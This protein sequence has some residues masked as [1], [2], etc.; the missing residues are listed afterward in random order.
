MKLQKMMMGLAALAFVLSA[1]PAQAMH[2]CNNAKT[3]CQTIAGPASVEV[4]GVGS[5]GLGLCQLASADAPLFCDAA[6]GAITGAGAATFASADKPFNGLTG[7][8]AGNHKVYVNIDYQDTLPCTST[9]AVCGYYA[10]ICNDRDL[11]S[12][13]TNVGD[14]DDELVDAW[15]NE[16][17]SDPT[18]CD[19][20]ADEK[21]CGD[22]TTLGKTVCF[23]PSVY[24]GAGTLA[25]PADPGAWNNADQIVVFIGAWA[26]KVA[27]DDPNVGAGI[28]AGTYE[29]SIQEQGGCSIIT[30]VTESTGCIWEADV[31]TAENS[32]LD[33]VIT[34]VDALT[35]TP[36]D[37]N[38]AIAALTSGP[39]IAGAGTCED[40]GGNQSTFSCVGGQ[41][42]VVFVI[43]LGTS[44]ATGTG[45]CPT[46]TTTF[47]TSIADQGAIGTSGVGTFTCGYLWTVI[48]VGGCLTI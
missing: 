14:Q 42:L 36:A 23:S 31:L 33:D 5:V 32:V 25:D 4:Q 41:V 40:D 11:D 35:A 9:M 47:P 46:V 38:A 7:W 15:S 48:A 44:T 29:V 24:S 1:F 22:P 12:S 28:S 6:A 45:D 18:N 10:L 19:K 37:V 39:V 26:G 34:A 8:T 20:K 21:D 13:C 17:A 2:D 43:G 30:G 27:T 3:Q 16:P